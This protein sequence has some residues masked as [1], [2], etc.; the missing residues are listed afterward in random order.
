MAKLRPVRSVTLQDSVYEQLLA[1]IISGEMRPGEKIN[2]AE[3]ARQMGVSS[4]PVREALRRLEAHN[5][6]HVEPNRRMAVTQRSA[7]ELRELLEIRLILEGHAAFKA[8]RNQTPEDLARLEAAMELL[9]EVETEEEYLKANT[10]FHFSL[11]R[12]A[13]SPQLLEIIE[14]LWHRVS[15]YLYILI[16]TQTIRDRDIDVRN[17]QGIIEGFRNKD[18]PAVRRWLKKDL[19][20]AAEMLLEMMEEKNGSD[21]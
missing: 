14:T 11:Y 21:G 8:A 3:V 15:P 20:V 7:S 10:E 19:N 9:G 13:R 18:A 6:V 4:Q 17:H 12:S 2:L 16:K 5:F 1:S